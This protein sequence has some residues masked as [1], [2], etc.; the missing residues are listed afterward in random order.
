MGLPLLFLQ[1][2]NLSL[3][4]GNPREWNVLLGFKALDDRRVALHL[5]A[6]LL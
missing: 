1:T 6:E 4:L 2:V 3:Q 5:L